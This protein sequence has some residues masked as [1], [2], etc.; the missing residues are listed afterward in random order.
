MSTTWTSTINTNADGSPD[1]ITIG[2]EDG[3][4]VFDGAGDSLYFGDSLDYGLTPSGDAENYILD[5]NNLFAFNDEGAVT[6]TS[7]TGINTPVFTVQDVDEKSYFKVYSN[8]V[9]Q[10]KEASELPVINGSALVFY[11]SNLY[12]KV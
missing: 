4:Y 6:F 3:N 7:L 10:M 8:G 11:D 2:L 1:A 9:V 5:G 12:A